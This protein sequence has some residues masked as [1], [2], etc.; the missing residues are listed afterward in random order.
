MDLKLSQQSKNDPFLTNRLAAIKS[1]EEAIANINTVRGQNMLS[2]LYADAQG[3]FLRTELGSQRI[4]NVKPGGE[5][6]RAVNAALRGRTLFNATEEFAETYANAFQSIARIQDPKVMGDFMQKYSKFLNYWKAQAVS[7]PGFFMRNMLGGAWINSALNNVPMATHQRVWEIRKAAI[8]KAKDLGTDIDNP[9]DIL[10]G[11]DQLI[12][13]NKSIR[14]GVKAGKQTVGVDELKTFREWYETGMAGQGQVSQEITSAL[15]TLGRQNQRFAGSF[16]PF[17]TDFKGFALIRRRNQDVEFMLRGA[18][19]HHTMMAGRNVDDAYRN[20]IKFHFDYSDLTNAERSVKKVIPF[21]VW[22]KNVLPVLIESMGKKPAA[23]GRL[24][25]VKKEMELTSPMEGIVPEYFGENMGIRMPF[26]MGGNRVYVLPDLPFRDLAKFTKDVENPLDVKQVGK[27]VYRVAR[28][29]A[30]P[31][32]K[33]PIEHWAGK[34]TFADIPLTGRFQQA[35]SWANLPG[36]KQALLATGLA[37]QSQGTGRLVMTDKNIYG[38]DQFM[39]MFGRLRRFVPNER[40]KQEAFWTTA[41]NTT[42]GTGLRVNT[43]SEIRAQIFRQQRNWAD[44][45]RNMKDI[46]FR[47]R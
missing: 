27:N 39:P 22:Q 5:A 30:L 7:T 8:K 26:K 29:S 2:D 15:D 20:V 1:Q 4:I 11:L 21:W 17:K 12:A 3:D 47:S 38:F 6:E 23:W 31:P 10:R 40:K 35:P 14:L 28:E 9:N 37:K 13:D 43:P 34:Q 41:I 18:M 44:D 25:Q 42:F 16:N 45:W 32:I 24:L 36:L 33:F 19:A 46:E